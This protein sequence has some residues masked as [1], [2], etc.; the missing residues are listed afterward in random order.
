[1]SVTLYTFQ[2]ARA[3]RSV[4]LEQPLNMPLMFVTLDTFQ[5][6]RPVRLV[7]LEQPSN[8]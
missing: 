4:R 8:M 5:P 1:M 2:L 7:R 6:A 3:V